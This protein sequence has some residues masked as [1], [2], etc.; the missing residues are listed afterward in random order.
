MTVRSVIGALRRLLGREA[1]APFPQPFR[2]PLTD[3]EI[4]LFDHCNHVWSE[5]GIGAS[6]M[7]V[8]ELSGS[9]KARLVK[10]GEVYG[11]DVTFPVEEIS[12]PDGSVGDT[13]P[14]QQ[15]FIRAMRTRTTP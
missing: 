10:L 6:S 7:K 8:G 14:V 15:R 11:L 3:E 4:A 1:S 2:H 12:H 5:P 13:E 9:L